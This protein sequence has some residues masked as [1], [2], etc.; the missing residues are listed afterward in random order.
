MKKFNIITRSDAKS[1][2]LSTKIKT[3]LLENNYEFDMIDPDL[4]IILGGDG[5]L[6]RT[7]HNYI[8]KID[9]INFVCV[10]TGTLG[11][12]ADYNQDEINSL[13]NS[14]LNDT[15]SIEKVHLLEAVLCYKENNETH[16]AL[17]ELRLENRYHTCNIDVKLNGKF[18]E[19]FK[20]NGLCISTP[21]GS[22]GYNKS[23]NGAVVLNGVEVL[24][25]T[26]IAGIHS[27]S[28]NSLGNS[29]IIPKDVEI[30][31]S[32]FTKYHL[33]G[34]DHLTINCQNLE[35]IK[36]KFSE[37]TINLIHFKSND[38]INRIQKAFI[39]NKK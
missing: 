23:L 12:S 38:S 28:Y 29:L 37:K 33:V 22:T 10:L 13:V 6:L 32:S 3:A 35:S 9:K 8:E 15:Y 18:F 31:L 1:K 4:I 19:T 30:E 24:Q 11:F 7:V 21:F 27:L 34:I 2:E 36:I 16:Y 20:G 17:N 5:K 25:M 26:E 14:I 39:T